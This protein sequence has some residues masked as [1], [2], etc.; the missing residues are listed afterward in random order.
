MERGLS[1]PTL[2]SL[3][4]GGWLERNALCVVEEAAKAEIA[5]PVGLTLIDERVYGDTKITILQA[6][7]STAI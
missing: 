1:A 3:L 5:A 2:V 6:D 4:E 7:A